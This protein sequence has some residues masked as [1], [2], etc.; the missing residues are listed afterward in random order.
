MVSLSTTNLFFRFVMYLCLLFCLS[1]PMVFG[2]KL[3]VGIMGDQTGTYDLEK[4]YQIMQLAVEKMNRLQPD[5]VVHIGDMVESISKITTFKDY[6]KNF[7]RA[8]NIMDQLRAPWYITAG[9]HDVVPPVYQ[10]VSNDRTREQWFKK[11]LSQTKLP[12]TD[13]L[14]YSVD[15]SDYHFIFLYSLENLH[16]D[17]RWGSIFLNQ[18][19]A[20]QINW[21]KQ[22]LALHQSAAGI[23]VF[24]H[25]PHWYAWSNWSEI[26]E[27]LRPYPV[28]AVVAGHY[29]SDQDDG[30]IDRIRY[31]V[32]GSTG[33]V[34][35][36]MDKNSGGAQ[37]ITLLT[38]ETGKLSEIKIYDVETDSTLELTP[39]RSMDRLQALSCML[40]NVYG[41]E[42][43]YEKNGSFFT[44]TLSGDYIPLTKIGLESI[45][46]PI[47]LPIGIQ[48][49]PLSGHLSTS[50]WIDQGD[51][52]S[53]NT[54][55]SL[56]PGARTG[57]S[58]YSSVGQWYK[59]AALWTGMLDTRA[60]TDEPV[61]S[62]GLKIHVSFQDNRERWIESSIFFPVQVIVQ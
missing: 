59:P 12:V 31:I 32:T 43:I 36:N 21:L 24:V 4:S 8:R 3:K 19:S 39:R 2:Q 44:T 56:G 57:W 46:N 52:T 7:F 49:T 6:Q 41:D 45:S 22:D 53:G 55:F 40:D 18:I 20:D 1:T 14:Y 34:I 25:H 11:L 62:I 37:E 42:A 10:P 5:L 51:S 15:F 50:Y 29:H 13:Q 48:I 61:K 33:G 28:L 17:P 35:K 38:I 26:H 54:T 30:S 9:D 16:T 47:D 58:N 60:F 27:I 23:L